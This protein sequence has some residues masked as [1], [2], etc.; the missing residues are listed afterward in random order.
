VQCGALCAGWSPAYRWAVRDKPNGIGD[1]EVR[2]ALAD[3][4]G[5]KI[6]ALRYAPV[7]FGS[8][9]WTV[10]AA[11]GTRWFVTVDDLDLKA[12]L[13]HT[14]ATVLDGLRVAMDTAFA[15]RESAGLRFVAAPVRACSGATVLPL[16]PRHAIAAFPLLPGNS[17]DF[18][19]DLPAS[20]RAELAQMLAALHQATPALA[21][22]PVARVGLPLRAELDN[23]LADLGRPW[24]GGPF[25]EPARALLT[26]SATRVRELLA[27][28]DEMAAIVTA[29]PASYVITHGE[30]HPGNVLWNGT[31]ATLIDWD[32]VGLAPPER[33][34]WMI[35]AS[36]GDELRRYADATGRP[37]DPAVLA[38]YRLRW[39]LD[40]IAMF[41]V[42]LRAPHLRTP[43]AEHAWDALQ[44]TIA[45]AGA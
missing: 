20:Q 43:G 23:A 38:F 15:L 13:G 44:I 45:A 16:G 30:P 7:G 18:G 28:F 14:R 31:G 39:A 21:R 29:A 9:H 41:L 1:D 3:G 4:W 12:W 27:T 5:V 26:E 11:D 37:A 42:E 8:Y 40:D 2:A 24:Q 22:P 33:D 34:L 32:T 6:A 25:A 35:A 19:A 17:G 10:D 36:G